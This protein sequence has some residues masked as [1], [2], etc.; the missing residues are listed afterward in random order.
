VTLNEEMC[1]VLEF[2][3]WKANWWMEQVPRRQ[4]LTAPLA[5]G[6]H[7][8]AAEQAA[9]ERQIHSDW[10]AKWAHARELTWP[11]I[12]AVMGDTYIPSKDVETG[13]MEFEIEE[14]CEG[15]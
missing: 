11:I 2:C 15:I 5:E 9:M 13:P 12:S 8:Y 1:W 7:A 14:D 6:L 4:G 3:E 10:A